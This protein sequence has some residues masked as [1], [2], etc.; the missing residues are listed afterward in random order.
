MARI[1][2]GTLVNLLAGAEIHQLK[3]DGQIARPGRPILL[4]RHPRQASL[5]VV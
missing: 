1:L 3:L 4:K 2:S 5:P